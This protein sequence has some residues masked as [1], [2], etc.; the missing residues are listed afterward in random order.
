MASLTRKK[1]E[2][3]PDGAS[4][5]VGS[6]DEAKFVVVSG[7]VCPLHARI[8]R[9][10]GQLFIRDLD[11]HGG[12]FANDREIRGDHAILET[13]EIRLGDHVLLERSLNAAVD[14]SEKREP[15]ATSGGLSIA[16]D[17]VTRTVRTPSGK[18]TIADEVSFAIAPG[19]F[20]GV[21]G[22]SGSGKSTLLKMLV[23]LS[24]QSSG[25][26]R[27]GG[28]ASDR[29]EAAIRP[30]TDLYA[31]GRSAPSG[32][33]CSSRL[34]VHSRLEACRSIRCWSFIRS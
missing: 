28:A 21:L 30:S 12:T 16:F 32:T 2:R 15:A 25:D 29:S 18:L 3:L 5:S 17:S 22:A 13:D 26:I 4:V 7:N 11:S 24:E 9:R 33:E 34:A 10:N 19:E 14:R 8:S 23:G 6:T 31:T 1:L 20:V 27:V